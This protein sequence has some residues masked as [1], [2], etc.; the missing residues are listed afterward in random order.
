MKISIPELR[1][2]GRAREYNSNKQA[3]RDKVVYEYLFKGKSHRELD[4]DVLGLNPEQSHGWQAM[5]ILHYLGIKKEFKGIF[6]E[7]D[8]DEAI[9]SL[10]ELKG[11]EYTTIINILKRYKQNSKDNIET[12][13]WIIPIDLNTYNYED[14]F[15]TRGYINYI[16]CMDFTEGDYVF[17]Y[18][19]TPFEK[20]KY[21][22]VV[23]ETNIAINELKEE[24]TFWKNQEEYEKSKNKDFCRLELILDVDTQEL[25]LP[26]LIKNGLENA[27][28]GTVQ[29][30]DKLLHY[31]NKKFYDFYTDGYFVDISDD[32]G[33]TEGL[34]MKV[35]VERYERS[36]VARKKCIKEKGCF[37]H[38][39]NLDFEKTY[40]ELG[41][42]FI[43]V[44]HIKPLSDIDGEYVVDYENDLV[45][46]CPNCHAMIH[47]KLNGKSVSLEQLKKIVAYYNELAKKDI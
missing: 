32:E 11:N 45:P 15:M 19:M 44:H 24:K 18:C 35:T 21:K 6:A 38:V 1:P 40:G 33:L 23:I 12:K 8:I 9:K 41:K 42:G 7:I 39:C 34:K 2:S 28:Q 46:L 22:T 16:Q 13:N 17:I 25:S 27:P 10:E 37:C 47:R 36:V 20:V 4:K 31:I 3:D 26:Y 5:G 14:S 43:H 30:S 29:L